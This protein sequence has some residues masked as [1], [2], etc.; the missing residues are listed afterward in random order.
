MINNR[1]IFNKTIVNVSATIASIQND[2]MKRNYIMKATL[3]VSYTTKYDRKI[4]IINF[5]K[6]YWDFH[7]L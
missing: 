5:A 3:T 1:Q 7:F 4:K 6:L 2:D